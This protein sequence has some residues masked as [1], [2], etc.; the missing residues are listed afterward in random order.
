MKT[1]FRPD[2]SFSFAG[3]L[4]IYI[5]VSLSFFG[6]HPVTSKEFGQAQS[7]SLHNNV[8]S[9]SEYQQSTES[10]DIYVQ[11]ANILLTFDSDDGLEG[12]PSS[13]HSAVH[14]VIKNISAYTHLHLKNSPN[15]IRMVS[16]VL[17]V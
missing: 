14:P 6:N 15:T 10:P 9:S 4:W 1:I 8:L 16:S 5:F 13:T 7:I 2:S 11:H 3:L 12:I 17:L